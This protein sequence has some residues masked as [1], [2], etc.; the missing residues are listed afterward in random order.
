MSHLVQMLGL[1]VHDFCLCCNW[2]RHGVC[3]IRD[4]ARTQS[5]TVGNFWVGL[6]RETLFLL[7]PLLMASQEAINELNTNGGGFNANTAHPYEN[8]NAISNMLEI[9]VTP[10]PAA[11]V[12]HLV[13]AA[14]RIS[15]FFGQ[16]WAETN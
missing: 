7:L 14:G 13:P 8:P 3:L 2:P 9:W 10:T 5:P 1:T 4:V 11:S 16:H 12:W 6:T 15:R